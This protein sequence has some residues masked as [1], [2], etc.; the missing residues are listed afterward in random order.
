[1]TRKVLL[2]AT[3]MIALF[4]SAGS[5]MAFPITW[6]QPAASPSVQRVTFWGR[7]FPY[8]YNWSLARACTRYEPV[9]TAHGTRIHRIW[10]CSVTRRYSMR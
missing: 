10:V 7:A 6:V 2:A 9:E 4:V 8:R 3:A 1:M 5:C